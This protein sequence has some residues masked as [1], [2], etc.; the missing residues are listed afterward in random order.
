M[1]TKAKG[2]VYSNDVAYDMSHC[3]IRGECDRYLFSKIHYLAPVAVTCFK[4]HI[5][6]G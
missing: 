4:T 2:G 3:V 6:P 5:I 1:S